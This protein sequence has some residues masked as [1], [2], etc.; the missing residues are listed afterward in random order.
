[1]ERT[2]ENYLNDVFVDTLNRI[3]EVSLPVQY[4]RF[5]Q[6]KP[7]LLVCE[8]YTLSGE[9]GKFKRIVTVYSLQAMYYAINIDKAL[10]SQE[11]L[12][13]GA[14]KIDTKSDFYESSVAMTLLCAVVDKLTDPANEALEYMLE[15]AKHSY[16][17]EYRSI[18]DI[19]SV[20][21]KRIAEIED[22]D[23]SKF[24]TS[25]TSNTVAIEF[26]K[27]GE[28][29]NVK[30][31][32]K[33]EDYTECELSD[34][35]KIRILISLLLVKYFFVNG[36]RDKFDCVYYNQSNTMNYPKSLYI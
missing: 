32:K 30:L 27:E 12:P 5:F 11:N 9:T 13:I 1:M 33:M 8:L 29:A 4:I 34:N 24:E 28:K 26:T 6:K 15:I 22:I 3:E 35:L 21:I 25:V 31:I 20:N 10:V 2:I 19:S 23:I 18:K 17:S 14:N 36:D 16:E 7:N